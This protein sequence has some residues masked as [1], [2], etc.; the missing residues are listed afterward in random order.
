VAGSRSSGHRAPSRRVSHTGEPTR[1][2][3]S[4][5]VWDS[6]IVRPG[7]SPRNGVDSQDF[8]DE[9]PFDPPILILVCQGVC[10]LVDG[11][12]WGHTARW[13]GSYWVTPNR[14]LGVG[15]D[16]SL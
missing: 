13:A 9:V 5:E 8:W 10:G 15:V 1:L 3:L 4:D 12:G 16:R 11:T 2:P 6:A 14:K 7:S